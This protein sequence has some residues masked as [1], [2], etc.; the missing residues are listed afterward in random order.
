M[1]K[2][3]TNKRAGLATTVA[4]AAS[5]LVL[6]PSAGLALSGAGE[7]ASLRD[8]PGYSA[9]TPA[10]IDPDMARLVAKRGLSDGTM[11]RFTPAGMSDRAN[12]SMTVAVRVDQRQARAYSVRSA[13]EAANERSSGLSRTAITPTRYNLGVSRG[14][15]TFA[16]PAQVS[17]E[18]EVADAGIPDLATFRPTPARETPSRFAARIAMDDDNKTSAS[19]G[20]I[21]GRD[22]SVAVAGSYRLTRNIDVTAGVR[23][24][25]DRDRLA[26]INDPAQNESQAVYIGTQFRF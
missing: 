11:T 1:G 5:A 17:R 22:Q 6:V 14:Y 12:R 9:F 19:A 18:R 20:P 15:Q 4:L 24:S 3:N 2:R 8:L 21:D 23:Y 13:I 25:Q 26:P 16:K 7:A 10:N